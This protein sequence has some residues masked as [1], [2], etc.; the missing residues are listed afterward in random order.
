MIYGLKE[1][2]VNEL[3]KIF[4]GFPD[5]EEVILYGSRAKGNY[6]PGSDIDLTFKGNNLSLK[7]LNKIS[8]QIDNLFLPYTFDLSVFEHIENKE[9]IDHIQRIGQIL[10][11]K[12][13]QAQTR[14]HNIH[15]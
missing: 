1:E 8:L 6:K 4:S 13:L 3:K 15:S 11:Q 9:L 14:S 10:Y 5:V 12:N 2:T 7:I